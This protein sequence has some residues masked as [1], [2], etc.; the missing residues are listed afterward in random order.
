MKRKVNFDENIPDYSN[1][2]MA[3]TYG[4]LDILKLA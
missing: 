3:P 1:S 2:T 4:K